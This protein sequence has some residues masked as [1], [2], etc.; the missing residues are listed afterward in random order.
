MQLGLFRDN[1]TMVQQAADLWTETHDNVLKWGSS[2]WTQIAQAKPDID[3][4][5]SVYNASQVAATQKPGNASASGNSSSSSG[6]ASPTSSG[7]LAVASNLTTAGN[8]SMPAG[9]ANST[10]GA[11]AAKAEN[12]TAGSMV[13]P[14]PPAGP[15][16][17]PSPPPA[18]TAAAG[19]GNSTTGGR[20]LL[21]AFARP[22]PGF[23]HQL[24][25]F[26][27]GRSQSSNSS[28]LY[29]PNGRSLQLFLPGLDF[30]PMLR[31]YKVTR[32]S[33]EDQGWGFTVSSQE[34]P[35]K[36]ISF[37]PFG[38]SFGPGKG[39]GGD[40][41][42]GDGSGDT[43]TIR[44]EDYPFLPR[45]MVD[46]LNAPRA[47]VPR[48][49]GEGTE[50]LR[51]LY[52]TQFGLGSLVQ[53]AELAWQQN[54]DLYSRSNSL[55]KTSMELHAQLILQFPDKLPPGW[56]DVKNMVKPPPGPDGK[57]LVW[58]FDM[59]TQTWYAQDGK[60]QKLIPLLDGMK[61]LVGV[62][63]LPFGWEVR[64]LGREGEE[65]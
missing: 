2:N 42:P 8:S 16:P 62:G 38:I 18:A 4:L 3:L 47:V 64:H 39:G 37:G 60:G 63:F 53:V 17:L 5:V 32:P 46:L 12:A 20:V 24:P 61:Y 56:A 10:A 49:R 33:L 15:P 44:A 54:I 6:G 30:T 59:S 36:V 55:M 34:A 23:Q 1:V 51:D 35:T 11:G 19:V 58:K 28:S 29:N 48:E 7:T 31:H 22:Q 26:D 21:W 50:T 27:A 45:S 52:H 9:I 43:I 25:Q 65:Q 14:P 13:L 41:V 40:Q 57:P